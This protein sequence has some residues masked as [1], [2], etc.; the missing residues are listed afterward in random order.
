MPYLTR[1]YF[2]R[3]CSVFSNN[4]FL[5]VPLALHHN[6][7]HL[8][9]LHY[10][11][12]RLIISFFHH[13]YYNLTS[14]LV[15]HVFSIHLKYYNLTSPLVHHVF[16]IHLLF[17]SKSFLSRL[18]A[19][20]IHSAPLL[21]VATHA[22]TPLSQQVTLLPRVICLSSTN[23]PNVAFAHNLLVDGQ[24]RSFSHPTRNG[25]R[26]SIFAFFTIAWNLFIGSILTHLHSSPALLFHESRNPLRSFITTFMTK[27]DSMVGGLN[28]PSLSPFFHLCR[29]NLKF[30]FFCP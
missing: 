21:S 2:L 5:F 7:L 1:R 18:F 6:I 4:N 19:Y 24:E 17:L 22:I 8:F 27:L 20:G 11:W 30:R 28:P 25:T 9:L 15:H 29:N 26:S 3:T 13:K 23:T 10:Y 14:P 12:L 16:S